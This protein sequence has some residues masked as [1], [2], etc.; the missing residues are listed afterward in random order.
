MDGR[1]REAPTYT[2]RTVISACHHGKTKHL[3][4]K[5][6]RMIVWMRM[7]Y[8]R[9]SCTALLQLQLHPPFVRFC[10]FDLLDLLDAAQLAGV[11]RERGLH[12]SELG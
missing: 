1:H 2:I 3:G 12:R 11:L 9:H 4:H 5:Q 7:E 6:N 8:G 10:I